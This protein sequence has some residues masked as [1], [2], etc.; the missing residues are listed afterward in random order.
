MHDVTAL[1]IDADAARWR[2]PGVDCDWVERLETVGLLLAAECRE[3]FSDV[4]AAVEGAFALVGFLAISPLAFLN[5]RNRE[6]VNSGSG[7]LAPR[8]FKP[9]ITH[10]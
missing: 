6:I 2:E 3:V 5:F 8:N 4:L 9:A 10:L 1:A 7:H